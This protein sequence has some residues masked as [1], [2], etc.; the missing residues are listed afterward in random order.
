VPGF[1]L[2]ITKR[3]HESFVLDY[4][5]HGKT[6]RLTYP[7]PDKDVVKARAWAARQR[8]QIMAQVDPRPLRGSLGAN[9]LRE[10]VREFL[11]YRTYANRRDFEALFHNHIFPTLGDRPIE[12]LGRREMSILR[13]DVAQRSGKFAAHV[14]TKVLNVVG[15]WYAK[16]RT[17][18]WVWPAIDS[19]LTK[20]DRE[21]RDRVLEDHEIAAI[22][23]ACERQGHPHG[24]MVE[25]LLLTA[26]RRNEIAHLHR[27]EVVNGCIHLP[28]ERVKTGQPLILPV[29]KMALDLLATCPRGEWFFARD[30]KPFS[31]FA[32]GK[33]A[34]DKLCPEVAPWVL[35]DLRR[36]AATLMERAGV[37]PHV[38]EATL[39]HKVRGVAGVY[40]RHNFIEEKTEALERLASLVFDIVK[41]P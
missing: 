27:S 29:S 35:H 15:R 6:G 11:Q 41:S 10:V 37:L 7:G 18:D 31:A 22:W 2:K 14:V 39:N 30:G 32:H 16:N 1:G 28:K 9:T 8:A 24:M 5:L 36:T 38:I 40:R 26:C 33:E 3:G 20:G 12:S 25:V 17:N 23:A 34:L 21:G 13:D 4:R 19:P